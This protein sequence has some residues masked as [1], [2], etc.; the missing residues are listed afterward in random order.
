[1]SVKKRMMM[2]LMASAVMLGGA[3]EGRAVKDQAVMR[4]C[5]AAKNK[6]ING[7][8]TRQV[9]YASAQ[10]QVAS[11]GRF[12]TPITDEDFVGLKVP[13][14]DDDHPAMVRFLPLV[15]QGLVPDTGLHRR[16]ALEIYDEFSAIIGP[17][18]VLQGV[19]LLKAGKPITRDRIEDALGHT[20]LPTYAA[21]QATLSDE[22]LAE[23]YQT[24]H[25]SQRHLVHPVPLPEEQTL[26]NLANYSR[27]VR[28]ALEAAVPADGGAA[29]S[30]D[31]E[32]EDLSLSIWDQTTN[33]F[34]DLDYPK[35]IED[36]ESF[37]RGTLE[38][39]FSEAVHAHL[40]AT[41][42]RGENSLTTWLTHVR[43]KAPFTFQFERSLRAARVS[44]TFPNL[45]DVHCARLFDRYLEGV[46]LLQALIQDI[47]PV[48]YRDRDIAE[49]VAQN[50]VLKRWSLNT[51]LENTKSDIEKDYLQ[52]HYPALS[53]EDRD[54]C[55][56]DIVTREVSLEQALENLEALN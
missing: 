8:L 46:P 31:P 26:G 20:I 29:S 7:V 47:A 39:S 42:T 49:D 2:G 14:C 55:A 35:L 36:L 9:S 30:S 19:E 23:F 1:M 41:A 21:P 33:Y 56:R 16:A 25:M 40:G 34:K 28:E 37:S 51:A 12:G 50:I 24:L 43:D 10:Q 13:G 32:M 11:W 52:I 48:R 54:T 44:D 18:Y 4:D 5:N 6:L 22:E 27:R 45:R 38:A 3:S 17:E 15:E 53:E